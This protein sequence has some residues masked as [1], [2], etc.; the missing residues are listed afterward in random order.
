[1]YTRDLALVYRMNKYIFRSFDSYNLS[2]KSLVSAQFS[3]S[4]GDQR[5]IKIAIK[6]KD[7]NYWKVSFFS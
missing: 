2:L 4:E 6:V 1:M 7:A 3:S 5:T